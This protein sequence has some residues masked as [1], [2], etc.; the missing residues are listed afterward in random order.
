MGSSGQAHVLRTLHGLLGMRGAGGVPLHA[1]SQSLQLPQTS[2]F[3]SEAAK[4]R[5][6]RC[7]EDVGSLR[8]DAGLPRKQGPRAV[9]GAG[10]ADADGDR[11]GVAPRG[12]DC[13]HVP[14]AGRSRAAVGRSARTARREWRDRGFIFAAKQR[15][16]GVDPRRFVGGCRL[17]AH[18][19][20]GA[21]GKE[22]A[23][24][25]GQPRESIDLRRQLP[26]VQ[27]ARRRSRAPLGGDLLLRKLHG[28]R[29][30]ATSSAAR[31]W[32]VQHGGRGHADLHVRIHR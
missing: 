13:G 17:P 18:G 22:E 26:G 30:P 28:D 23:R 10:E 8:R 14:G 19:R 3:A 27:A 15:T 1:A 7:V 16:G 31:R 2:T 6:R 11:P 4:Q 20:H 32:H 9:P 24:F 5:L 21:R 25:G 12:K 29:S